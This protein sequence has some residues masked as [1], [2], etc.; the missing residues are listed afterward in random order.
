MPLINC[1]D[2]S[3]EISSS[4]KNCP[5]CGAC[6]ALQT[7]WGLSYYYENEFQSIAEANG[8]YKGKWNWSAFFFGPIWALA[9][10][11]WCSALLL[12][13]LNFWAFFLIQT[14][15]STFSSSP[16]DP[17]GNSMSFTK[18]LTWVFS[19]IANA[20]FALK[21]NYVYYL[22]VVKGIQRGL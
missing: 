14:F 13:L 3:K 8:T 22:Y 17:A 20:V 18:F 7:S 12:I 5:N 1:A 2:C 9:K 15:D 4:S 19:I 6:L 21:A 11:L 16:F 10:G